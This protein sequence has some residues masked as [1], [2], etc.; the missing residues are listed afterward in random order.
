M[1]SEI[2]SIYY[3]AIL[4]SLNEIRLR[5]IFLYRWDFKI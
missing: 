1:L 3:V 2:T 5:F 4:L